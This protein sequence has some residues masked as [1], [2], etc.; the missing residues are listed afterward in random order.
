MAEAEMLGMVLMT[1]LCTNASLQTQSENAAAEQRFHP[2]ELCM[3]S[4]DSLELWLSISL[5]ID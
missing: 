2:S 1:Q 4:Q 5:L 3:V